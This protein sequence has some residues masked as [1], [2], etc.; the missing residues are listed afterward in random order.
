MFDVAPVT[1]L[2]VAAIVANPFS[3]RLAQARPARHTKEC[4]VGLGKVSAAPFRV[5][6]GLAALL[7]LPPEAIRAAPGKLSVYGWLQTV[8]M[9]TGGEP[10]KFTAKLDTGA[11]SS[12]LHALDIEFFERDEQT[13]VGF[14]LAWK[15]SKGRVVIPH[16]RLERPLI[17]E[18]QIR[19]HSGGP[20]ARPVVEMPICLDGSLRKMQVN[21][22]DRTGFR[23]P[24]LIGR[25]QMAGK[26][27]VDPS[28]TFVRPPK[29]GATSP[30]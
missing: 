1:A 20:E 23:Y 5:L 10:I 7:W 22:V 21:L 4:P 14:T 27:I 12:S 25:E 6:L 2:G 30:R 3:S 29:C 16:T 24:L 17:T 11:K 26:L 8:Q 15:N 13:W 9:A 19:R 28:Q 18:T